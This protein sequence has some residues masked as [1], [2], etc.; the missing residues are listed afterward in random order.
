MSINRGVD[1]YIAV[2]S[3]SEYE[4]SNESEQSTVKGNHMEDSH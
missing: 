3:H 1:K 2:Q 4:Q